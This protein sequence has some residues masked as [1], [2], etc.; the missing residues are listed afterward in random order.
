[1]RLSLAAVVASA[2]FSWQDPAIDES[3]GLVDLGAT[4][5][6]TNDSGD[7]ARLFV[8]D[9]DGRTVRTV[10]FDADV[11]DVEALAPAGD[12]AVWVGDVGDNERARDDLALHR[13]RLSDGATTSYPVRYADGRSY[14]A[15]ALVA[16]PGGRLAVVTKGLVGEVWLTPARLR[17]GEPNELVRVARVGG[18]LT[19]GARDP[20]S[21]LV[22]LRGYGG[23]TV[24]E[25]PS[26]RRVGTVPLPRQPQGEGVSVG[27]DGRVRVSSEGA[28]TAV[29]QLPRPLAAYAPPPGVQPPPQPVDTVGGWALPVWAPYAGIGGLAVV[30]LGL[31]GWWR[32]TRPPS[33]R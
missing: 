18:M 23:A 33:S 13:V 31:V 19:D 9:G 14:D 17:E 32:G 11:R 20:L 12:G 1:M 29:R 27:P 22:V 16:L 25:L 24:H 4:M 26:W 8:V 2:V 6:T 7:D 30:A 5:V 10:A 21:G 28:G 15:E 3:S